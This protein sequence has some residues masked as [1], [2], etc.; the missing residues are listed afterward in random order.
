MAK[1]AGFGKCSTAGLDSIDL[2]TEC[3]AGVVIWVN[4]TCPKGMGFE[5]RLVFDR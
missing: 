2:Y 1:G 4:G 3:L 5:F